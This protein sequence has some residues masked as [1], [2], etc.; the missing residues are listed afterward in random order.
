[1]AGKGGSPKQKGLLHAYATLTTTAAMTPLAATPAAR[2]SFSDFNKSPP[3]SPTKQATTVATMASMR[4]KS[5]TKQ[6]PLSGAKATKTTT[7]DSG[8][9]FSLGSPYGG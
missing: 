4:T 8:C 7:E 9:D 6:S 2:Q 1:M 3:R 5:Q